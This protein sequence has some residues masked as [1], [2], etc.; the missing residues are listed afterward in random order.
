MTLFPPMRPMDE[1]ETTED[2][3]I[4]LSIYRSY[5]KAHMEKVKTHLA[6]GIVFFWTVLSAMTGFSVAFAWILFGVN[7]LVALVTITAVF[8]LIFHEVRKKL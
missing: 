4:S 3:N 8:Y 2:Y 1:D 5:K 7:G 6:I